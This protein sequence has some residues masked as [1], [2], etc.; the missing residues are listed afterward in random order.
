MVKLL[1]TADIHLGGEFAFLGDRGKEYRTQ[2]LATFDKIIDMAIAEKVSLFLIAGDLFNT[3][4][5][6]GVVVGKVLAAFKKLDGEGIRVCILPGTHDVYNDESIYRF[7]SFPPNVT[8]LTPE[9]NHHIYHDLDATVYGRAFDGK[10]YSGSPLKGLSLVSETKLHIGMAHCSIKIPEKVERETMLLDRSEIAN[11]GFD[12]MALGHWHSFH[13][14][15]QGSTK[16]FY[17]GSPEPI[18]MDQEGAGNVVLVTVQGK[19]DVT[20]TPCRVGSKQF[21]GLH[22]NI[23]LVNE[24]ADIVKFIEAR[25]NP[26]L[27]LKVTLEGLCSTGLNPNSKELED[28]LG[29]QFFCLRV[30]DKW[31]PKLDEVTTDNFPEETVTGKFIK[32]M[33]D[34]IALASNEEDK[35]LSKEALKLGFALLR[36]HLQ[37]IE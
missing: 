13:D 33:R 4:R 26:D 11:S 27:I 25:A 35:E 15:S 24:T 29:K 8:V 23:G 2:L 1:H 7:V 16:A 31:Q 5:V 14:Y 3:N 36:G 18:S 30:M 10:T 22:I 34:K 37:V 6:H 21:D 28:S 32:L 12:Y 20:V 17:C 19:G 9:N